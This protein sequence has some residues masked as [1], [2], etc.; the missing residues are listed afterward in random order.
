MK[1]QSVHCK[2]WFKIIN[3]PKTNPWLYRNVSYDKD[4]IKNKNGKDGKI[5]FSIYNIRIFFYPY[6]SKNFKSRWEA[7]M[8]IWKFKF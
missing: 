5:G 2:N 3:N 4:C 1:I 8:K 7:Y 6:K